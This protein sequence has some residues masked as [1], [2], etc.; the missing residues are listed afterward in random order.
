MRD[1]FSLLNISAHVQALQKG[2]SRKRSW[3]TTVGVF[4]EG[5]ST[6]QLG[7]GAADALESLLR[8]FCLERDGMVNAALQAAREAAEAAR[9]LGSVHHRQGH[10]PIQGLGLATM[11]NLASKLE[12]CVKLLQMHFANKEK[13]RATTC[14]R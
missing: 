13:P 1:I 7:G 12:V 6:A 8:S 3:F 10:V 11:I 9:S 2:T 4:P 14:T 5:T